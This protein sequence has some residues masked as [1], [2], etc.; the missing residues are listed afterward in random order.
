MFC[1]IDLISQTNM[2]CCPERVKAYHILDIEIGENVKEL[3]E[4]SAIDDNHSDSNSDFKK[5]IKNMDTTESFNR[6]VI[7]IL[8]N[9]GNKNVTIL[10]NMSKAM[11]QMI[12]LTQHNIFI[13]LCSKYVKMLKYY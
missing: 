13:E 2:C 7:D 4:E 12:R 10:K 11:K 5:Y 9:T 3:I 6:Y 8:Q 1:V